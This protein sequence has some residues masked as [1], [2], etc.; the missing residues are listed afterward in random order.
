MQS[1]LA[2][3]CSMRRKSL[4][5]VWLWSLEYPVSPIHSEYYDAD[6]DTET[7]LTSS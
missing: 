7:F 6:N 2:R 1:Y 3:F 4:T 5:I